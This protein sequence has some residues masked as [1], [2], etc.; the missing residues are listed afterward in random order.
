MK[1]FSGNGEWPPALKVSINDLA[2]M[3]AVGGLVGY[4]GKLKI[5]HMIG[6]GNF[7]TYK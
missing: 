5:D 6:Q 1:Y 3:A 7:R 4:L 2:V